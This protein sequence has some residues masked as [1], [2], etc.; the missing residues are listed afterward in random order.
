MYNQRFEVDVTDGKGIMHIAVRVPHGTASSQ[1]LGGLFRVIC[2]IATV[3]H[4]D[5]MRLIDLYW[6]QTLLNEQHCFMLSRQ[7]RDPWY[8]QKFG[9]ALSA[10]ATTH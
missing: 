6:D 1:I 4:I 10:I 5:E 7:H 8:V 9:A 3:E 2:A